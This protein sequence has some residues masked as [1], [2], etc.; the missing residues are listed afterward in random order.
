MKDS[1]VSR[2]LLQEHH[3]EATEQDNQ[4]E[5]NEKKEE[6]EDEKGEEKQYAEAGQH[7]EKEQ[8]EEKEQDE[9]QG[10][11]PEGGQ[12]GGVGEGE[13]EGS[14]PL[15]LEAWLEQECE[16]MKDLSPTSELIGMRALAGDDLAPFDFL[17]LPLN[18]S[19]VRKKN[20]TLGASGLSP[21]NVG[22]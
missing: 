17:R 12:G 8:M 22:V 16:H 9:G 6:G 10:G 19:A 5:D 20:L 13:G 18:L 21:K 15:S 3:E 7:E 11:E 4:E 1:L 14:I 2:V